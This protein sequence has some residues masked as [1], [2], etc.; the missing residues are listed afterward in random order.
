[1]PF[2]PKCLEK[3]NCWPFWGAK[4]KEFFHGF[5]PVL[6]PR[7]G[8]LEISGTE[9]SQIGQKGTERTKKT[10][11]LDNRNSIIHIDVF[12]RFQRM[13]LCKAGL[14]HYLCENATAVT[15]SLCPCPTARQRPL[16]ASHTLMLLSLEPSRAEAQI[17]QRHSTYGHLISVFQ[18]K[19]GAELMRH[20]EDGQNKAAQRN[21]QHPLGIVPIAH[22]A[23]R[24]LPE[25]STHF[26]FLTTIE[27]GL[28]LGPG[29]I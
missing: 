9:S 22:I 27:G 13:Q 24:F 18:Q 14:S 12:C 1:M 25:V 6:A 17:L 11:E 20:A 5:C 21:N 15:A 28:Q 2:G 4:L 10:I 19:C 26:P 8:T 7:F 16:R 3:C 29:C 23:R